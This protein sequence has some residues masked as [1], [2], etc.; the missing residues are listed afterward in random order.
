MNKK[1]KKPAV[2]QVV[3]ALELIARFH[4]GGLGVLLGQVREPGTSEIATIL[5]SFSGRSD[6]GV[7]I[8]GG[9]G[10]AEAERVIILEEI[11]FGI[12]DDMGG[13]EHIY[14]MTREV[15]DTIS[16]VLWAEAA[17]YAA[18]I[19]QGGKL[20]DGSG[21]IGTRLFRTSGDGRYEICERTARRRFRN[22]LRIIALKILSFP[23]DGNFELQ[24][25]IDGGFPK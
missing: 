2:S 7:R 21:G 24:A 6:L 20:R 3:A 16:P 9:G 25:S 22:L 23:V 1:R 10:V 18:H 4:P 15:M 5:S 11:F 12:I 17:D 14:R 8:A 19:A 13:W